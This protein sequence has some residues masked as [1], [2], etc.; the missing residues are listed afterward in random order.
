[1]DGLYL[2]EV[3]FRDLKSFSV[4]IA[5]RFSGVIYSSFIP[6]QRAIYRSI[7]DDAIIRYISRDPKIS[8]REIAKSLGFSRKTIVRRV[9]RL[10]NGNIVKLIPIIDLSKSGLIMFS[11]IS[12][13]VERFIDDVR[14]SIVWDFTVNNTGMI[15]MISRSLDD[16]KEIIDL[17][18]DKDRDSMISLKYRYSFYSY[19]ENLI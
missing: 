1:M 14:D 10:I 2:Y 7:I 4:D 8:L 13:S 6:S 18:R 12:R 16:A 19:Y 5:S 3:A 9:K 11:A 15:I 17:I